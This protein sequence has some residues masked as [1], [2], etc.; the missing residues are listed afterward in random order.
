MHLRQ[1]GNHYF[2]GERHHRQIGLR[3]ES[4]RIDRKSPVR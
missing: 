1:E 2:N 4:M 3:F